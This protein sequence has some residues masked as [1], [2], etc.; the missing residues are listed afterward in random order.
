MG[1]KRSTERK[2]YFFKRETEIKPKYLLKF[3]FGN[4]MSLFSVFSTTSAVLIC[5]K[6]RRHINVNLN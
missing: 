1:L 4:S 3:W 5:Y 2:I 6:H